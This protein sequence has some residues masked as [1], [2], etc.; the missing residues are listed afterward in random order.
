[1]NT[2]DFNNE[3]NKQQH[4]QTW[5][6]LATPSCVQGIQNYNLVESSVCCCDIWV[7]RNVQPKHKLIS[8]RSK[9]W[10][11]S[12]GIR[13]LSSVWQKTWHDSLRRQCDGRCQNYFCTP[14]RQYASYSRSVIL[15]DSQFEPRRSSN[16]WLAVGLS[17]WHAFLSRQHLSCAIHLL[18]LEKWDDQ[19]HTKSHD[20]KFEQ[21]WITNLITY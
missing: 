19:T 12:V 6:L 5:F 16:E 8:G 21:I 9:A 10:S 18:S 13:Y 17:Q 11:Y 3:T 4:K 20:T 2:K 7:I 1:M 14:P 15:N